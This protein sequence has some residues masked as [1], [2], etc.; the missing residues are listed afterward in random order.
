MQP[1]FRRLKVEGYRRLRAVDLPLRPLNVLIGA[2][3]VGKTSVLEVLRLLA[4]SA[5]GKLQATLSALGGLPSLLTARDDVRALS[6]MVA[7]D[8]LPPRTGALTYAARLN[9]EG[10]GYVVD[11]ESLIGIDGEVIFDYSNRHAGFSVSKE[12]LTALFA[13]DSRETALWQEAGPPGSETFTT[14]RRFAGI[15]EILHALDVS[16]RAPIR[17]PQAIGPATTPGGNGEDVIPC[18]HQMRETD[19]EGFAAVEDT[20][21][22]AFPSFVRLSF[23]SPASGRITLSWH[24]RQFAR[25]FNINELSE[26]TLRFLWLTTL[27]HSPGLP[28][29]T[30]IDEPELG[31]HPEMLKILAELMRSASLRSQLC[32]ATHSDNLV[33]FLEP[34]E[35]VVCDYDDDGFMTATR[36]S[37]L[38]LGDWLGDY[39]L[40]QLWAKGILGGRS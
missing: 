1:G 12:D 3:G 13:N 26:G 29:V 2:N 38:D 22:A 28:E 31:L 11:S 8:R 36:A 16:P 39:T 19:P 18:L 25:P 27:L 15:S 24:D 4:Q 6:L 9:L 7:F 14:R 34:E 37:E 33:R 21:R 5:D 40:D 17:T 23:P 20:L 10:W 35:V 30:L 32:V